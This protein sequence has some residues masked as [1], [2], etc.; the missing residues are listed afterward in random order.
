MWIPVHRTLAPERAPLR[1]AAGAE[2]G[3]DRRQVRRG[4][5]EDLAPQLRH[6]AA[7]ARP[8]TTRAIPAHDPRYARPRRATEL[9]LTECL[10]DT[11]ARFLPYWH[12]TIAPADPR[13]AD[14][15]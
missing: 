12:E 9:P 6:P 11:V 5:G 14:A 13:R 10:K 7:A 4:A 1:R 8:P 2:Q 3:R 15:C